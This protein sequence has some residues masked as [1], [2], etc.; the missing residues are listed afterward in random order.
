MSGSQYIN[1]SDIMLE[2]AD[3]LQNKSLYVSVP[4]CAYYSTYQL[5]SYIW[6][7]KIGKTESDISNRRAG[8][9]S[10]E[11]MINAVKSYISGMNNDDG[12]TFNHDVVQLKKLRVVAD[13]QDSVIDYM[14]GNWAIQLAHNVNTILKKYA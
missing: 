6:F 4:H 2:S 14:K 13:Y 7:Y 5:I 10:H 1:K 8:K 3:I 11:E 12:R 9:G